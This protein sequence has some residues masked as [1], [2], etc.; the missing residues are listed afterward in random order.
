MRRHIAPQDGSATSRSK[1]HLT[2]QD[3]GRMPGESSF[4]GPLRPFDRGIGTA[5]PRPLGQDIA[6]PVPLWKLMP[7]LNGVGQNGFA[8]VFELRPCGQATGQ[9]ADLHA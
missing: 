3:E 7:A 1:P 8:G 2:A 9:T 5:K 4:Y 6:L